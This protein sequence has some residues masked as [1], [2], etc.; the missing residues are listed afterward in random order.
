MT[1][2]DAVDK[3]SSPHKG[4]KF[5]AIVDDA[6]QKETGTDR[7]ECRL[8]ELAKD[9]AKD[10]PSIHCC[11]RKGPPRPWRGRCARLPPA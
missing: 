3:A 1:V 7:I 9:C 5:A 2:L 4:L 10:D 11:R 6:T 8:E